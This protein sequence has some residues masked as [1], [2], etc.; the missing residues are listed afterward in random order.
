MA[1]RTMYAVRPVMFGVVAA[2][3]N[4]SEIKVYLPAN[5]LKNTILSCRCNRMNND[6]NISFV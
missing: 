5:L 3:A 2:G 4:M 6:E 1:N